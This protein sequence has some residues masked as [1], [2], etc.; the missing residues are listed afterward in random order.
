MTP[1][2]WFVLGTLA[3]VSL[4]GAAQPVIA[5][6]NPLDP[7]ATVAGVNYQS[8]FA[9]FHRNSGEQIPSPDKVW[10]YANDDLAKTALHGAHAMPTAEPPP[11]PAKAPS[12]DHSKH[13]TGAEKTK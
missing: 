7:D 5:G 9:N 10:R 1:T 8:A 6:H 12:T 4:A 13:H 2:Q 3:S 11:A